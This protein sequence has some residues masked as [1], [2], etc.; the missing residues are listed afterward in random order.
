MKTFDIINFKEYNK[1]INRKP[2]K[3]G[4][5]LMNAWQLNSLRGKPGFPGKVMDR[6]VMGNKYSGMGCWGT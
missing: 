3:K 4:G 6:S 1:T 2:N 5:G